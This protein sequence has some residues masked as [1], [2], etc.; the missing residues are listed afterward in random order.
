MAANTLAMCGCTDRS[1]TLPL[2][3]AL[4]DWDREMRQ[5][6]AECFVTLRDARAVEPLLK[7]VQGGTILER[8]ADSQVRR[9]ALRALG[10]QRDVRALPKLERILAD[11]EEDVLD[12]REAALALGRIGNASALPAI[13]RI[14]F[15]PSAP[16]EPRQGAVHAVA[17]FHG[18]EDVL[19]MLTNVL[20]HEDTSFEL[21]VD[22]VQAMGE[23]GSPAAVGTL[24]E[25][26]RIHGI[27]SLAFW[28]AMSAVRVTDRAL[29]DP[30][31]VRVLQAPR[32][33]FDPDRMYAKENCNALKRLAQ[34]GT[35]IRVRLAAQGASGSWS[36][37]RR[38]ASRALFWSQLRG[39][40]SLAWRDGK[41]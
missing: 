28:A 16:L 31:V 4:G 24:L 11:R 34:H 39:S 17:M 22:V 8:V 12:R 6:A 2:I 7:L 18:E 1:A 29:A 13:S 32:G 21:K 33:Y 15:D 41:R 30:N 25:I 26:V 19:P 27:N 20:W 35:S 23:Y 5:H 40:S 37:F 38:R 36:S 9:A 10:N 14:L 3:K